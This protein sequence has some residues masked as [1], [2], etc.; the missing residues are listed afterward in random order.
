[1]NNKDLVLATTASL[2]SKKPLTYAFIISMFIYMIAS[3]YNS[4]QVKQ[5]KI[6]EHDKKVN[7][8]IS[9][10]EKD[11]A[12]LL[13]IKSET[14]SKINT[15]KTCLDGVKS[16]LGTTEYYDCN[17][18]SVIPTA[19]ADE[20]LP[21][22]PVLLDR[23]KLLM[24]RVCKRAPT[25]ELCNNW[26][27]YFRL[28]D[29]DSSVGMDHA[30]HLGISGHES[31]FGTDYA[32]AFNGK[33][34]KDVEWICAHTNNWGGVKQK[35][36]LATGKPYTSF[37]YPDSNGCYLAHYESIEEY[38]LQSAT[39]LKKNYVD[40]GCTAPNM[41]KCISYNYVGKPGVAEQSWINS[42]VTIAE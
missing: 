22:D 29:I 34:I 38:W 31:K 21:Y 28:K 15:I 24:S 3:T 10:L 27:L 30:V 42:V 39:I 36:S 6:A 4:Y 20:E 35:V 26:P 16:T 18:A 11:I 19:N 2:I 25:S 12:P 7:A 17:K 40:R 9:K 32:R 23:D 14:D 41:V 13:K 1:M 37:K 8:F 5:V 33:I